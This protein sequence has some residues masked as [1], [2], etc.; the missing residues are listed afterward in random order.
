[1]SGQ[2]CGC[3]VICGADD[4]CSPTLTPGIY[5]CLEAGCTNAEEEICNGSCTNTATDTNHCGDCGMKC[6]SLPNAKATCEGGECKLVCLT[7]FRSCDGYEPGTEGFDN[8]CETNI[9]TDIDHCG[10]C[11]GPNVACPQRP[12]AETI[13]DNGFCDIR[14]TGAF[15]NCDNGNVDGCETPIDKNNCY[16][17]D[18]RC[19]GLTACCANTRACG[20][21]LGC[22]L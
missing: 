11:E 7:G 4:P 17:C 5:E 1:V 13:C 19:T 2:N 10:A 3:G 22:V 18:R 6:E 12:N 16:T 20:A 14:C 15:L 8:G 9:L 21:L